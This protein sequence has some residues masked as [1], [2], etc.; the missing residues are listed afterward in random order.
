MRVSPTKVP[1]RDP[2]SRT[3]T[4]RSVATSS[5]WTALTLRSSSTRSQASLRPTTLVSGPISSLGFV[6]LPFATVRVPPRTSNRPL[7]TIVES[8]S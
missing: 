1:L 4:P 5:M 2:R 6:P 3:R 7:A 8:T